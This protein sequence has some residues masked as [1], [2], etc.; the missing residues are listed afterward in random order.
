MKKILILFF[1]NLIIFQGISKAQGNFINNLKDAFEGKKKDTVKN[2]NKPGNDKI[3]AGLKEALQVGANNSVL[4]ANKKDGYFGDN[5]IKIPF[6]K[7]AEFVKKAVSSIPE[8]GPKYVNDFEE[9]LNRAA[10]SAAIKA[11]P[12][13]I[14]AI[15][16]MNISDAM[17]ILKGGDNAATQ[18][19]KANTSNDLTNAFKPDIQKSLTDAGAEKAWDKVISKYNKIPFHKKVKTDLSEYATEKALDGLFVLIADEEAKI[20]K[21]PAARVTDLLKSVF[22]F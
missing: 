10:E 17:H 12:I 19:L 20:R 5:R 7:D 21:D 6:P 4:K 15:T 9:K 18:Y 1:I 2:L 22:G 8:V 13:F 14:D 3:I 11:K 16:K